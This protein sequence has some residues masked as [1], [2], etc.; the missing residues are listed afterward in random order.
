MNLIIERPVTPPPIRKSE[1]ITVPFHLHKDTIKLVP[2]EKLENVY[3]I[4]FE[5]DAKEECSVR[6]HIA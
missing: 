2:S 5:F 3:Y 4:N 6:I 1:N